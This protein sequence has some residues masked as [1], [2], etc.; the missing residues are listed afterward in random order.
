[1]IKQKVRGQSARLQGPARENQGQRVDF[2]Q[3]GGFFN[4]FT[5][6]RGIGLSKPLDLRSTTENR[7]ER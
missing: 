7:S 4:N 6:I 3:T 2:K 1:V 5:T